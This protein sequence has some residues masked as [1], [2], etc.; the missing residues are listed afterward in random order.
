MPGPWETTEKISRNKNN[1]DFVGQVA[2]IIVF[3]FKQIACVPS[4]ARMWVRSSH[5]ISN[6]SYKYLAPNVLT[7]VFLPMKKG[8]ISLCYL[9][10]WQYSGFF[11]FLLTFWLLQLFYLSMAK[12]SFFLKKIGKFWR[13]NWR[14]MT[15]CYVVSGCQVWCVTSNWYNWVLII[16]RYANLIIKR[17]AAVTDGRHMAAKR[18]SQNSFLLPSGIMRQQIACSLN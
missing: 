5:M 7:I 14:Q 17:E 11:N 15:F 1:H 12:H 9:L 18:R 3:P 2:T 10:T 13:R 6:T 8:D 16:I 4:S